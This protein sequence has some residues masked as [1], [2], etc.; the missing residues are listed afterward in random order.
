MTKKGSLGKK[1]HF[2]KLK[3]LASAWL[4]CHPAILAQQQ[5]HLCLKK[6]QTNNNQGT[7]ATIKVY[8][9]LGERETQPK[10]T[11]QIGYLAKS[12]GNISWQSTRK[13]SSFWA[14]SMPAPAGKSSQGW[15]WPI[16]HILLQTL[17]FVTDRPQLLS[18]AVSNMCRRRWHF[19][20]VWR[21]QHQS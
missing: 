13:S 15:S 8:K 19:C 9:V 6:K 3:S 2:K 1:I 7:W 10:C 17:A 5:T 16:F 12:K 21:W 11:P 18:G 20:H 4:L 14:E